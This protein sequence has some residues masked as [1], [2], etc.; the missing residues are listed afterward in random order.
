MLD[1]HP[2]HHAAS[3]WRDF[4]VHIATI[5]LGLCIAVG[6]EQTVEAIHH[7]HLAHEAEELLHNE[8]IANRSLI[9]RDFA[10]IDEG[11]RLI[12]LNMANLAVARPA[13]TGSDFHVVPFMHG[14]YLPIPVNT[15]WLALRDNNLLAIVPRTLAEGYAK[16]D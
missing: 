1:V 9:Q 7:R 14:T 4:F 16:L 15:A 10:S 5:V 3:T 12:R 11:H 13:N 6:L 2:A 8:S